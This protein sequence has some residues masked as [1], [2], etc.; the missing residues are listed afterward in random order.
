MSARAMMHVC[1][2]V[3]LSPCLCSILCTIH[4]VL[5]SC[6]Y[7]S[8]H[9]SLPTGFLSFL[10][11]LLSH[12]WSASPLLVDPAGEVQQEARRGLQVGIGWRGRG[13]GW[14]VQ[15]NSCGCLFY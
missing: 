4:H 13:G 14:L 9:P 2:R 5:P 11:L 6:V 10:H 12:P 15:T 1:M 8:M 7:P 3:L